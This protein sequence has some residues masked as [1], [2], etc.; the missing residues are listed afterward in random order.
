MTRGQI[1]APLLPVPAS[2]QLDDSRLDE[3]RFTR[4][5]TPPAHAPELAR[6]PPAPA[7]ASALPALATVS[8]STPAPNPAP[9]P[10][11]A[12]ESREKRNRQD[13][14][15]TTPVREFSYIKVYLNIIDLIVAF[16]GIL[17]C[18]SNTSP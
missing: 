7:L 17:R 15:T 10:A 1:A 3:A 2:E 11:S 4:P 12:L 5:P 18:P 13:D 6:A 9:A 16:S 14:T 8:V